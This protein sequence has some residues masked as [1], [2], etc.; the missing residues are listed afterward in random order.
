MAASLPWVAD[1][2]LL[3]DERASRSAATAPMTPVA[4]SSES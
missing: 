1:P 3:A 2:A 4:D